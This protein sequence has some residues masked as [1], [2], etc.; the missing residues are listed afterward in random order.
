MAQIGNKQNSNL[1]GE[2]AKHVRWWL[3][4]RTAGRRRE[5]DK[6]IIKEAVKETL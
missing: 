6:Q 2:W 3:K 1:N 5:N 4:R